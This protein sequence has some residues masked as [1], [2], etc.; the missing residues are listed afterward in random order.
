[1]K[2]GSSL[3]NFIIGVAVIALIMLVHVIL[4]TEIKRLNRE[5]I[6]KREMLN[7]KLNLENAKFVD[8]QKLTSEDKIVK[9]AQDSLSLIRPTE[10]LEI[11]VVPKDQIKQIE[12][13]VNEKYD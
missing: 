4:I 13:L 10:N 12:K 1:M 5:K 3:K 8:V 9:F 6:T 2:K 7:E 11:I